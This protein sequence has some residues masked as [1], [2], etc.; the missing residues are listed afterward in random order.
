MENYF[1]LIMSSELRPQIRD[2]AMNIME[3]AKSTTAARI[4]LCSPNA[5]SYPHIWHKLTLINI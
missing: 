4:F 5:P 3:E 2:S 1:R